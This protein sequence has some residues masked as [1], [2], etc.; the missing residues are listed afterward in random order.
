MCNGKIQ[1]FGMMV[2]GGVLSWRIKRVVK[3]EKNRQAETLRY[4]NEN[5][6]YTPS[7]QGLEKMNL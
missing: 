1:G 7:A 2:G 4:A 3:G 5:V 6:K